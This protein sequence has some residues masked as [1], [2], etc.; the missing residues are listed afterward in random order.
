MLWRL[1]TI[2]KENVHIFKHTILLIFCRCWVRPVGLSVILR[3]HHH[4]FKSAVGREKL[5]KSLNQH[6][7]TAFRIWMFIAQP[8]VHSGFRD[9]L[10]SPSLVFPEGQSRKSKEWG[11][12]VWLLVGSP[13]VS[14]KSPTKLNAKQLWFHWT[15]TNL[16]V[17]SVY[18]QI[19]TR[20][21]NL[22]GML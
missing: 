15:Y 2:F 9:G 1:P 18:L 14:D 22:S 20:R 16:W 12:G 5:Q 8:I 10:K 3:T 21:K 13:I 11:G 7:L 4:F 6:L 17:S 19:L